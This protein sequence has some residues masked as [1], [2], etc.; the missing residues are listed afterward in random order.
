LAETITAT[1]PGSPT[2]AFD[3]QGN[4]VLGSPVVSEVPIRGFAP[5]VSDN[6]VESYGQHVISAATVYAVRGTVIPPN[7]V[8]TIRGDT[9]VMDG[10]IGDFLSPYPNAHPRARG[11]EFSVKRA[12]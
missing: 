10:E 5:Q 8:L 11:V 1:V 3:A 6:T 2:G 12:T 4:P 9:W 7:A